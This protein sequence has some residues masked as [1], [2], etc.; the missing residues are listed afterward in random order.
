MVIHKDNELKRNIKEIYSGE[1]R[2]RSRNH[3]EWKVVTSEL[4]NDYNKNGSR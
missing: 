4:I 1:L 2:A 3:K